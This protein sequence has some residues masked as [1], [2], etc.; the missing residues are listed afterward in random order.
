VLIAF[1]NIGSDAA[2]LNWIW[3]NATPTVSASGV[4]VNSSSEYDISF[5]A[6]RIEGQFVFANSA[7]DTTVNLHA[8]DG[9]TSCEVRGTADFGPN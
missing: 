7:G 4:V 3:A 8:Y 5:L 9:G 1:Q 2:T 6:N